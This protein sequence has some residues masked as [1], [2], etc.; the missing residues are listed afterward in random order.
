MPEIGEEIIQGLQ[1]AVD[2]KKGI[3]S[4][5]DGIKKYNHV[6]KPSNQKNENS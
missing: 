3:L 1:E 2:Y 5:K 4:E 6:D